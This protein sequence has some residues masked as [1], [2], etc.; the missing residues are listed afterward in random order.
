M[1]NLV[2]AYKWDSNPNYSDKFY[3]VTKTYDFEALHI[4]KNIYSIALTIAIPE[5]TSVST[6]NAITVSYRAN[7]EDDWKVYGMYAFGTSIGTRKI[8]RKITNVPSIQLKIHGSLSSSVYINDI[9]IEYR[10]RK[11]RSVVNAS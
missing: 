9:S 8:V 11:R 6:T 2:K 10:T 4:N 7:P 1:A 5:G 3:L